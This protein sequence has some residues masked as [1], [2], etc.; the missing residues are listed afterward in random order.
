MNKNE[1]KKIIETNPSNSIFTYNE[2]GRTVEMSYTRFVYGNKSD[3]K[4]IE[5]FYWRLLLNPPKNA[6]T[7]REWYILNKSNWIDNLNINK[8]KTEKMFDFIKNILIYI[9]DE[10]CDNQ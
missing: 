10:R 9:I 1:L 6:I 7:D 3:F 2:F 8:S 4:C 5:D